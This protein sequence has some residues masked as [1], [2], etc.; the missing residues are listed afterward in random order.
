MVEGGKLSLDD[1]L[2]WHLRGNHYPPVHRS[3]IPIAKKAI[4]ICQQGLY[5]ENPKLY[6]KRIKM[7]NGLVRTAAEIVEGLHLDGFLKYTVY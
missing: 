2:E 3:F 6:N 5:E 1:A 7:P 4:E